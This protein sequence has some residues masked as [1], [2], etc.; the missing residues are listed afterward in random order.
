MTES[1]NLGPWGDKHIWT[2]SGHLWE[3]PSSFDFYR[4]WREK[5]KWAI[6]NLFFEEF[7]KD[8]K[9]EDMDEFSRFL[10]VV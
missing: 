5:P 10:L 3:A 2:H 9:G 8:G 6:S 4:A 7:L 1:G